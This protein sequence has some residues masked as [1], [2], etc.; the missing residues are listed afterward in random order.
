MVN[1]AKFDRQ[2][3]VE[4]A[5]LLFWQKGFHAT[6]MRHLQQAVDL[7]PGS[8]YATFGSKEGLFREALQQYAA[9]GERLLAQLHAQEGSALRALQLFFHQAIIE[10][11]GRAPSRMCLLAKTV[12]ELTDANAELLAEARCQ[13]K[14]MEQAFLRLLQQAQAD[15]ELAS[16]C[17]PEQLAP[18]LQMQMMGLRAY[19]QMSCDPATGERMLQQVF[20]PLRVVPS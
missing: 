14:R 19:M 17:L 1:P 12:A 11:G 20:M 8:L 4:Q 6:S 18:F 10:Q 15:G 2:Q 5:M 16:G 7:R 13:L 9:H 3:V